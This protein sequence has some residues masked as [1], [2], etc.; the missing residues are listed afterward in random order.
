MHTQGLKI[1]WYK[2]FPLLDDWE[3]CSSRLSQYA[4]EWNSLLYRDRPASLT[5]A[6]GRWELV[7]RLLCYLVQQGLTGITFYSVIVSFLLFKHLRV[8]FC[9]G[10]LT[11]QN[12][13]CVTIPFCI[14]YSLACCKIVAKLFLFKAALMTISILTCNQSFN[15][16]VM[17]LIG[18]SQWIITQLSNSHLLT[19]VFK[20]LAAGFPNPLTVL[21][22][23]YA[24]P[25]HG[26]W[27]QWE[28]VLTKP[29][30]ST[31]CTQ[32]W[33]NAKLTLHWAVQL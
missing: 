4:S 15:V 5:E 17:V 18:E 9:P 12:S 13:S 33:V 1:Q 24:C 2:T 8:R 27:S 25:W 16:K 21:V 19:G 11:V 20:H 14:T 3:V 28:D 30:S 32:H 6:W 29:L 31:Y 7:T 23:S 22:Y 26:F 10:L